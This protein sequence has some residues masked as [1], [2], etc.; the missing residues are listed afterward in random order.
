MENFDGI[1]R[2]RTQEN[3]L[4][5]DVEGELKNGTKLTGIE[6]DKEHLTT[7]GQEDFIEHFTSKLLGFGLGC[8]LSFRIVPLFAM[9]PTE[10]KNRIINFLE[11]VGAS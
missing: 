7:T 5:I 2:W 8:G 11:L 10:P 1:G 3:G 9:Q 6:M 4:E